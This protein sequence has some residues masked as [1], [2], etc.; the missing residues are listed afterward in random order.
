M[1]N[2]VF[3]L[4]FLTSFAQAQWLEDSVFVSRHVMDV[5]KQYHFVL[6]GL[7]AIPGYFLGENLGIGGIEGAIITGTGVGL[8]VEISD[9]NSTGFDMTDLF[10][11][12]A[13]AAITG[14]ILKFIT[15]RSRKTRSNTQSNHLKTKYYENF[16]LISVECR[17][18]HGSTKS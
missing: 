17:V 12:T 18:C 2:I 3:A 1:R 9:I 4:I 6:G 16:D 5:D 11:T 10:I 8:L 7:F 14:L 13:G 15:K